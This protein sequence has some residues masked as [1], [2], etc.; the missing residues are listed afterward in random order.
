MFFEKIA[1]SVLIGALLGLER[2]FT[3]RQE[4]IGVRTFAL[5]SLLGTLSVVLSDL[6]AN[7]F[8]VLFAFLFTALFSLILYWQGALKEKRLGF[9]TNIS[10]IIVF[11]LG[12]LAGFGLFSEAVFLSILVA[13][14]LY[15]RERLHEAVQHLS[16]TEVSELLEFLVLLG[17]VFPIL[18]KE[19]T[20]FGIVVPVFTIW[21]LVVLVSF[22]NFA[23]FI[24]ARFLPAR[25]EVTLMSFLGGFI[26]TTLT[27]AALANIHLQNKKVKLAVAGVLLTYAALFVRNTVFLAVPSPATLPFLIAPTLVAFAVLVFLGIKTLTGEK[28]RDSKLKLESPFNVLQAVKLGVAVFVIFIVLSFAGKVGTD[29]LLLAA[30]IG[31]AI[32]GSA[33]AVSL[34]TLAIA[35]QEAAIALFFAGIGGIIGDVVL[36]SFS[37][38]KKTYWKTVPRVSLA[39]FLASLALIASILLLKT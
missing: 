13:I 4:I 23:A 14:V 2:E 37:N 10:I 21:L 29:F 20:I 30:L 34:G 12:M 35:P 11:L 18:P 27:I 36:F 32:H 31:G 25:Q 26:S 17:I 9:T 8:I 19:A 7:Q 22:I 1:L 24:G 5:I 16:R 3:K 6:Y 38:F 39:V 28:S 33:V 15:S